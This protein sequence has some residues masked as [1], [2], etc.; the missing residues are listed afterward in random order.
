MITKTLVK[1][2][3]GNTLV[4]SADGKFAHVWYDRH[5]RSW[6]VQYMDAEGYQLA[7]EAS[8]YT[9]RK[10]DAIELAEHYLTFAVAS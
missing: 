8:D 3:R 10:A 6:V 5:V 7:Y 2:D 4:Y 9:Y 1:D